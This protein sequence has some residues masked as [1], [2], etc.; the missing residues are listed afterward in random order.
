ME[1]IKKFLDLD[2]KNQNAGAIEYVFAVLAVVS[3]LPSVLA[4][5]ILNLLI[6]RPTKA[7]V[8]KVWK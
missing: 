7:L 8:E 5:F 1:K 3:A 2:L 6:I 4:Y